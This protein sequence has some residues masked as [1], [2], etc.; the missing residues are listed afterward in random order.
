ME[1]VLWL[2]CND[3][4]FVSLINEGQWCNCSNG[5]LVKHE[6]WRN[7]K[8]KIFSMSIWDMYS[9]RNVKMFLSGL[10]ENL[11]EI[12]MR[13]DTVYAKTKANR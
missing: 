13:M 4:M 12:A 8:R 7:G 5:S 10:W 9:E 11:N 3:V 6:W 1:H 2:W